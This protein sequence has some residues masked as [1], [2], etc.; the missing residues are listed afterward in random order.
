MSTSPRAYIGN[1]LGE[2]RGQA[3]RFHLGFLLEEERVW[4]VL[5]LRIILILIRSM[6]NIFS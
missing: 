3:V 6:V 2:I 5:T 4:T 1:D